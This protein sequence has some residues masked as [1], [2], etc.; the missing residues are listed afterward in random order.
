MRL[1]L[2]I[3]I[4]SCMCSACAAQKK[5]PPRRDSS[6]LESKD[7]FPQKFIGNWKGVVHWYVTG[8]P[9]Q[10]F[11]MQLRV[12][13]TGSAGRYTW[14]IVYGEEG[15]DVRSYELVA[16]DSAK[17]KW[18]IDEKNGIVLENYVHGNEIHGI[19]TV[20]GSTILNNYWVD[21]QGLLNVEFF[22]MKI[23]EKSTTGKGTEESPTVDNYRIAGYQKGL[24]GRQR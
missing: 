13:P 2:L 21:Q 12:H 16:V 17:G 8:K 20:G 24:L 3:A 14:Q 7:A 15:K 11:S 10:T 23:S 9:R 22:T 1:M 19:F 5:L 6:V 18:N 4:L